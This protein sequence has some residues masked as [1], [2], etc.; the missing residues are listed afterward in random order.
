[1]TPEVAHRDI[2]DREADREPMHQVFQKQLDVLEQMVSY[3]TNLVASCFHSSNRGL[4][5]IVLIPVLLKHLVLMLD[6]AHALFN[7]ACVLA[8]ELQCRAVLEA[9]VIIDFLLQTDTDRRALYYY[10]GQKRAEREWV[11]RTIPGTQAYRTFHTNLGDSS[12]SLRATAEMHEDEARQA[13]AHLDAFLSKPPYGAVSLEFD[14]V[15]G[16]GDHE[17]NWYRPLG[18]RSFAH[19]CSEVGR[20]ADYRVFYGQL[21]RPMHGHLWEDHVRIREGTVTFG[22]LRDVREFEGLFSTLFGLAMQ[23]YRAILGRYRPYQ[24]DEFNRRFVEDWRSAYVNVP[25]ICIKEA[26]RVL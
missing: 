14:R 12:E 20:V 18:F 24:L 5:D 1:M 6:G 9:S 25:K 11:H 3:G 21:S 15:R 22:K 23:T 7:E 2:L 16:N 13:Q 26:R 4:T 8:A 19:L 10:V 17:P